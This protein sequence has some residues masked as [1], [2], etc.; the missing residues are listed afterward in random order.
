MVTFILYQCPKSSLHGR[1]SDFGEL[2]TKNFQVG[3]HSLADI[4]DLEANILSLAIAI[5]PYNQPLGEL[6]LPLQRS[7]LNN[8]LDL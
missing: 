1:A 6:C 8:L 2:G 4:Y 3:F 5:R 7:L